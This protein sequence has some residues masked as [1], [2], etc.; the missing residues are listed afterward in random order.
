MQ[1]GG[2]PQGDDTLPTVSADT[3]SDAELIAEIRS[4]AEPGRSGAWSELF[5]RHHAAAVGFAVNLAGETVAADLVSDCFDKTLALLRRGQGPS[6]AFRPYL[7]TAIRHAYIDH[8]RRTRKEFPVDDVAEIVSARDA[9]LTADGADARFEAATITRAF[10]SLPDRWRTVLWHTAVEN[11]PLEKV[12]QH[13]GMNANSVAALSFRAREGLRRAYLAEHLGNAADPECRATLGLLAAYVRGVLPRKQSDRVADHL[14]GCLSCTAARV[15]LEA[16]NSNLGG[17]LAP[18]VLGGALSEKVLSHFARPA[19]P[20]RTTGTHVRTVRRVIA[21]A[22]A[23]TFLLACWAVFAKSSHQAPMREP[24]SMATP[25]STAVATPPAPASPSAPPLIAPSPKP[26]TGAT[27]ATDPVAPTLSPSLGAPR[28]TPSPT[29]SSSPTPTASPP[30]VFDVTVAK[31]FQE[32]LTTADPLWFHVQFPVSGAS[33]ADLVM[34]LVLQNV[35][36][37][38][39]HADRAFGHW[40]CGGVAPDERQSTEVVTCRLRA[41]AGRSQ[42]FAI[43]VYPDGGVAVVA[44]TVQPVSG[45]DPRPGNNSA[46]ARISTA[47]TPTLTPTP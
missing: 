19:E 1:P 25:R 2:W 45:S 17:L 14:S 3:R 47:P 10:R 41:A 43:D 38:H 9:T 35:V 26:T 24:D 11:E 40:S 7:L 37:Y 5:Q 34:R 31:P 39:V 30:P 18:A 23:L 33:T 6:E 15:D 22:V 44:V 46:E 8:L 4:D 12:A 32:Q 36:T 42:D 28:P 29:P 16:I 27:M 13:L 20:S 21:A